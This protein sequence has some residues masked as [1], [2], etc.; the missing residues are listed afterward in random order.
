MP[1]C[2]PRDSCFDQYLTLMIDSYSISFFGGGGGIES[3]I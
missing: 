1:N 2:N 3:F